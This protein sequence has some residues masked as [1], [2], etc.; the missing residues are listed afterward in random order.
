M[1]GIDRSAVF[2]GAPYG[3]DTRIENSALAPGGCLV[4]IGHLVFASQ[5]FSAAAMANCPMKHW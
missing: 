2:T 5:A 3:Y 4:W 1:Y